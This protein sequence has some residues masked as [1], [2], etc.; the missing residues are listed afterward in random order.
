MGYLRRR[1]AIFVALLRQFLNPVANHN[2]EIPVIPNIVSVEM[3]SKIYGAGRK[4]LK[5]VWNR[6]RCTAAPPSE[7]TSRNLKESVRTKIRAV[8]SVQL[9]CVVGP[10]LLLWLFRA[11]HCVGYSTGRASATKSFNK[12]GVVCRFNARWLFVSLS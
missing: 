2:A 1:L 3:P 10:I 11:S 5:L 4:V 8:Q 6:R 7:N 12:N 9:I